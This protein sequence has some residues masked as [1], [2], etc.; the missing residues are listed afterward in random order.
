MLLRSGI[1]LGSQA[2]GV[3]EDDIDL[4]LENVAR[5]RVTMFVSLLYGCVSVLL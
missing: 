4:R 2:F 3:N 1:R 5:A